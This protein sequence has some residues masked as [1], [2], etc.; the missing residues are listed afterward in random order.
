ERVLLGSELQLG[1]LSLASACAP[2]RF[3][4]CACPRRLCTKPPT[5]PYLSGNTLRHV[6][7]PF[8]WLLLFNLSSLVQVI[9]LAGIL[10]ALFPHNIIAPKFRQFALLA[11]KPLMSKLLEIELSALTHCNLCK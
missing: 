6:L 7:E 8:A 3:A 5:L 9:E 1:S 10:V 2:L 4:A 11:A